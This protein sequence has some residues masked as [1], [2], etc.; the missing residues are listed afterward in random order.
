ML[1]RKD[2]LLEIEAEEPEMLHSVLSKLPRPLN[3]DD[4]IRQTVELFKRHPPDDLPGR[5]WSR[6]S[7]NSVLKTTRD[8]KALHQ[9]SLQDG[10]RFFAK[11]A[12]E[13]RR[14]DILIQ[15]QQQFQAVA[16]RYQRPATLTSAAV[17]VALMAVFFRN[18][19][20]DA[21]LPGWSSV[22]LGLQKVSEAWQRFAM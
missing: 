4:L 22:V 8:L 3:L 18:G 21:T 19:S 16:R 14:H 20:L 1:S 7:S 5:T 2:Q 9:Q 17:L 10:E 15:K 6:V 13:I 12:A 11:E